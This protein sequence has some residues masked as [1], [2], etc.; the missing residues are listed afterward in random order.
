MAAA[1]F[2][3]RACSGTCS[4]TAGAT[5][6]CTAP[7]SPTSPCSG[8]GWRS[9][10]RVRRARLV[11]D[12]HEVWGR[13]YWRSYLGPVRGRIGY[14]R[15][16]TLRHAPGPQLH[17][18]APARRAA[19]ADTAPRSCASRASTS[20]TGRGRAAARAAPSEGPPLVVVRR[21]AHPGEADP[22][23]PAGG[24]RP[25]RSDARAA[26]RDPR[27]RPRHRG[28]PCSWRTSSALDGVVELPG[29]VP[30]E[31]GRAAIARSLLPPP[32]LRARGL[33]D[34]GGGG[35]SRAA[36]PHRGRAGP[37]TRRPS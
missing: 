12:W 37:K 18:L 8:P 9:G 2:R 36:R 24:A 31:R 32:P 11:V 1:A 4:V 27:R 16:A 23:D 13:D 3:A 21:A 5:T 10:S 7:P 28:D 26:L 33:R 17:V 34:G 14:R 25:P 19:C 6:P 20:R 22:R 29:R 15:R 30:P 35:R